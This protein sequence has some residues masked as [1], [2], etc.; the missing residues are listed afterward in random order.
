MRDSLHPERADP[1]LQHQPG[2]MRAHAA[3][4]SEWDSYRRCSRVSLLRSDGPLVLRPSH[5]KGPEPLTQRH[6]GVARVSLAAGSAGPLGG[7]CFTLDITVGAGSTLVLHEIA[8]MLVLPGARQ[9]RSHM[10]IRAQV[11]AGACFVWLT[12]PVIAARNCDHEHDVRVTLARG[13]R[14]VL[15]EELLLGRHGEQPG[16]I[17]LFSRI[18]YDNAPLYHQGLSFGPA[19]PGWDSAAVIGNNHAVGSLV[20]VDPLWSTGPP[21]AVLLDEDAIMAPLPGPG[22]AISAVAKD[23]L[24]LRR[25]LQRGLEA[26]GAPWVAT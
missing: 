4:A 21:D 5:P 13:A 17:R 8:A 16:D 7:D 15:R 6:S 10:R 19:S 24:Q 2:A 1:F 9:A 18:T 12:E 23:S 22:I 3:L 25:L 26:L 11:E 20:V 14:M